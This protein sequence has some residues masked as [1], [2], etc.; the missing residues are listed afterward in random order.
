MKRWINVNHDFGLPIIC[1]QLSVREAT[2]HDMRTVLSTHQDNPDL[3][4]AAVTKIIE[5]LRPEFAGGSLVGMGMRGMM[6]MEFH[7]YHPHLP[8]VHGYR[9]IPELPLIPPVNEPV[10][11]IVTT[12]ENHDEAIMTIRDEGIMTPNYRISREPET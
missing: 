5:R 4:E 7:Y 9:E 6:Q 12:V 1:F 2:M 8:R 11:D 10:A 3:L